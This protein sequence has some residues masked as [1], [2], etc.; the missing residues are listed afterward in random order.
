[1]G[2][3]DPLEKKHTLFVFGNRNIWHGTVCVVLG[4]SI[5]ARTYSRVAMWIFLLDKEHDRI[6]Y[7]RLGH[8]E[9]SQVQNQI[10]ISDIG[11]IAKNGDPSVLSTHDCFF[12]WFV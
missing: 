9:A 5:S 1:M 7:Q 4:K 6:Y 8:H 3:K 10:I 11:Q 2:P 12:N